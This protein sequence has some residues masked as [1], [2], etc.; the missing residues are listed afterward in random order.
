MIKK[1]RQEPVSDDLLE[2]KI[3]EFIKKESPEVFSDGRI[4][5]DKLK[6]CLGSSVQDR[7]ERYG[8]TWAGKTDCFRQ[9]QQ[10]IKGK[11]LIPCR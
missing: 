3:V 2:S 7:M 11:T 1:A 10:P 6:R 8:L 5:F 4:D 9:I